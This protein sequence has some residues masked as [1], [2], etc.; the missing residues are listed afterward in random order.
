LRAA[1][2]IAIYLLVA[3]LI[4]I[5]VWS[6]WSFTRWQYVENRDPKEVFQHVFHTPI[7]PGVQDLR[8]AGL[9]PLDGN[10]WMFIRTAN[11][12]TLIQAIKAARHG[13]VKSGD[14]SSMELYEPTTEDF[15]RA[16]ASVQ[17]ESAHH[18]K[19]P[20]YYCDGATSGW[21]FVI[22]VDRA[23]KTVYVGAMMS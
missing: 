5:V 6:I 15:K 2:W 12:D 9:Q 4:G 1:T 7:P 16:A 3:W 21:S 23:R 10:L 17:W 22:V 13:E 20:E 14:A 19:H 11:I 8:A 18:V